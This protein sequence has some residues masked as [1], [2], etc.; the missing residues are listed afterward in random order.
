MT[1]KVNVVLRDAVHGLFETEYED[2]FAREYNA[3]GLIISNKKG[4]VLASFEANEWQAYAVQK[5]YEEET[6]DETSNDQKVGG[7]I[8]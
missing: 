7:S 6:E 3:G 4:E 2:A 8:R 1:Q 5:D